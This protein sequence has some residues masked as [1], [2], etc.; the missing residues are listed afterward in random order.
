MNQICIRIRKKMSK[1]SKI[2]LEEKT[3]VDCDTIFVVDLKNVD[4][5]ACSLLVNPGSKSKWK[6]TTHSMDKTIN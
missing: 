3:L 4:F 2:L 6:N 5:G 1:N